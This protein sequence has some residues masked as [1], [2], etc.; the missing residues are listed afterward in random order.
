MVTG[1]TPSPRPARA[2][3]FIARAEGRIQRF[4]LLVVFSSIFCQLFYP[5]FS[6]ARATWG[7]HSKRP[8][9]TDRA[10]YGRGVPL[11]PKFKDHFD[12]LLIYERP[13]NFGTEWYDA[14]VFTIAL[15]PLA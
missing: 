7:A 4:P 3:T 13:L 1:V 8:I 15:R 9:F 2:S 14:M 10:T 11:C 6:P 5:S 12:Y